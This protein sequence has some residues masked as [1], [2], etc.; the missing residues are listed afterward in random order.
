MWIDRYKFLHC[1][2]C[3]ILCKTSEYSKTI[4]LVDGCNSM[5]RSLDD[6][7]IE[8]IFNKIYQS[9]RLIKLNR[10]TND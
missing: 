10:I 8:Y 4:T 5:S 1:N 2:D 9:D 7:D 6:S 3:G